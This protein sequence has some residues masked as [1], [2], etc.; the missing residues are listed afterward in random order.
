MKEIT[1]RCQQEK[2]IT[3]ITVFAEINALGPLIFRSNKTFQNPSQPIGFMYSP[4]WKIT[5]QNPSVLCTPPC[6]KSPIKIHRFCV[7]PPLKITHQNPSVLCT[8]PFEISPIRSSSVSCSPPF[9]KSPIKSHRFCV[10]P[11]LKYHPSEAHRF[12]VV[13]PLKNHP[14]ELIGFVYSP[15]WKITHQNPFETQVCGSVWLKRN[16]SPL[17]SQR[18]NNKSHH[19]TVTANCKAE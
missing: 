8:P 1:Y 2:Y 13:P 4:L 16:G 5:H 3:T 7:L 18:S 6:E 14:S 19:Q 10:L 11:P 12:Y 9:E 15:L 17:N